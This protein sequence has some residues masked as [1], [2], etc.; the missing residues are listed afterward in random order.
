MKIL[1]NSVLSGIN[2][3]LDKKFIVLKIFFLKIVILFYILNDNVD[4]I[5]IKKMLKLISYDNF[6]FFF[7]LLFVN[8]EIIVFSKENVDVNVVNVNSVRNIV[9]KNLLNGIW[10]NIDGNMI[11]SNLGFFVGFI[12]NENMVGKMV[13]FVNKEINKFNL[14]IVIVDFGKFFFLF[15]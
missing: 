7:C 12:F 2:I 1:I 9:K 4:G 5:F 13:R 6:V 10:L 3:L 15:K 11:N 8:V 14:I